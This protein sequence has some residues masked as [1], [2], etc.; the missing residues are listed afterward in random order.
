MLK[1]G[2]LRPQKLH[3]LLVIIEVTPKLLQLI[4]QKEL[5]LNMCKYDDFRTYLGNL[6]SRFDSRL[7]RIELS[8]FVS[9]L[10]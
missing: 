5:H 8:V 9:R 4:L 10:E 2:Q 3:F 1:R 6:D 7:R